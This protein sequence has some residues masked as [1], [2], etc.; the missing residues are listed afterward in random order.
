MQQASNRQAA[1]RQWA[2]AV[3]IF[4]SKSDPRVARL[5]P[6]SASL[7][8]TMMAMQSKKTIKT[9]GATKAMKAMKA[10]KTIK[11]TDE[12]M[13][14]M[15]AMKAT[16]AGAMKAMK[17]MKQ[18]KNPGEWKKIWRTRGKGYRLVALGYAPHYVTEYWQKTMKA[19]KKAMKAMKSA[20][21]GV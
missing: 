3:A 20:K 7:V 13:K 11:K 16:K 18:S 17:A 5:C 9:T 21:V 4:C 8:L 12:A 19:M 6:Y 2:E 10:A 1:G 14:A 15:K